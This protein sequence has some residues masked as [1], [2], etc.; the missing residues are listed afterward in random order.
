MNLPSEKYNLCL[1][2][3]LNTLEH[4]QCLPWSNS[5]LGIFWLFSDPQTLH[6][7]GLNLYFDHFW[8]L[9]GVDGPLDS[10]PYVRPYVPIFPKI[11]ALEFS[12]FLY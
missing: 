4:K 1:K 12:D 2:L 7:G 5:L 11:R 3:Y 8:S 6:F 9:D 10:P